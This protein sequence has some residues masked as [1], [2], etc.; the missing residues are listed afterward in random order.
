MEVINYAHLQTDAKTTL[1]EFAA[2][3][4]NVRL[5]TSN[6]VIPTIGVFVNGT[7][8]NI[9]NRQNP[10][11]ATG[12]TDRVVIVPGIDFFGAVTP[13]VTTTPQVGG[14]V[15]WTQGGVQYKKVI[16]TVTKEEPIPNVP[17]LYMLGVE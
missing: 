13:N 10:T 17:I 15:E 9:D 12:E 14:T 1:Q 6:T 2:V 7:A 11:W 5:A 3:P 16:S 4:L 8:K